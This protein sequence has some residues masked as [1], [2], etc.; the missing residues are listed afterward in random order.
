MKTPI[1]IVLLSVTLIGF[2]ASALAGEGHSA[3]QKAQ[4]THEMV[5]LGELLDTVARNSGKEFLVDRRV[6]A[7]VVVGTLKARDLDYAMFL[8]VLRNNGLAAIP[9]DK[10]V[11]VI[12]VGNVRQYA[13]PMLRENDAAVPDDEW[14]TRVIKVENTNAVK[15]VSLLR[16]MIQQAGHLAADS[17]A[18]KLV[19]VAPY[20]VTVR[21]AEVVDEIDVPAVRTQTPQQ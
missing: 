18:N 14:V 16:P 21:V 13:P 6:P 15:L 10:T 4:A 3:T 5:E 12:P 11:K 17:D 7:E 20:G 8:T 1:A 9:S 2:A 19:I